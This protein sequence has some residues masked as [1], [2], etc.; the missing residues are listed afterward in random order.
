MA[1]CRI[2]VRNGII[3]L[4]TN[5]GGKRREESLGIR[6]SGKKG[7]DRAA[8]NLAEKIREK[9]EL[10]IIAGLYGLT[11]EG[12]PQTLLEYFTQFSEAHEET[13]AYK[14]IPYLEKFDGGKIYLKDVSPIWFENFVDRM[15]KDS[16]LSPAT[17]ERYSCKVRQCLKKAL[18][19]GLIAR[20]PSLGVR[21]INVPDSGKEFLTADE[22][23]RMVS[24]EFYFPQ[25]DRKVQDEI[26]RAF[27]FGCI[28]GFR[29]SDIMQLE[30]KHIDRKKRQIAKRQQKTKRIV[31]VPLNEDAEALMGSGE[32]NEGLVFP[33]IQK[34]R[35]SG[36]R[37]LKKWAEAAGIVKNVSWH[38]ARH[39]DATLLIESGADLYTVQR[40]LGHSKIQ[41]TM[42]Y[43]VVSD[44]KKREAVDALPGFGFSCE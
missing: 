35:R 8:V 42:Q 6:I 10:E 26:R 21:H 9:R 38:T 37:Y 17:Q 34:N 20:D 13:Q 24:T 15:K 22:L 23:K 41:T 1:S 14:V 7:A 36:D 29:V 25:T 2:R 28:T 40:L 43:A 33:L 31:Y 16:G 19:E 44:R 3:H 39:T 18:R 27:L 12:K 30:W 11:S 4:I 5:V 32:N